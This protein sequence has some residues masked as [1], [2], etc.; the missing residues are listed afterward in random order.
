ML[1]E[2]LMQEIITATNELNRR[3]SNLETE[4]H[5]L[6]EAWKQSLSFLANDFDKQDRCNAIV[7]EYIGRHEED[8]KHLWCNYSELLE[9]VDK[10]NNKIMS[11]LII[12]GRNESNI[13]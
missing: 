12:G 9:A 3:V 2:N 4:L 8:I 13:P 10:S 6:R 1:D 5:E 11:A 7:D